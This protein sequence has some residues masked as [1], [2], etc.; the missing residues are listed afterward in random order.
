MNPFPASAR[1]WFLCLSLLSGP[2]FG[3]EI[4]AI[5]W[6]E[7]TEMPEPRDGYASGNVGGRLIIIGGTYWEGTKGDWRRKMFS[8]SS[9]ALN[10]AN[11]V[12]E[13]LP[14]APVSLGY[15]ASAQ[16]GDDIYAIGGLQDGKPGRGVYVLRHA[17]D[18]FV[19]ERHSEIPET[20]L[21]ASA[22]AV[23]SKIYV[24]GGSREYEPFDDKGTCC[25][26]NT[27]TS[28]VWVLDTTDT[29]RTWRQLPDYP[30][31]AR[32]LQSAAA[33][34]NDIYLFGGICL[35][36]QHQPPRQLNDVLHFDSAAGIWQRLGPLPATMQS[37]AAVRIGEHIVLLG[38][39]RQA[40]AFDPAT[41]AFHPVEPLTR[42]AMVTAF[43]WA[44]PFIVGAGGENSEDGP[45]RRSPWTFLGRTDA[46]A[47]TRAVTGK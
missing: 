13:R 38:P 39:G 21:F 19:F 46:A 22:V 18:R 1:P 8:R 7:S 47:I 27:A 31:D 4:P 26:S 44:E 40:V 17:D 10:P 6:Q 41:G 37:A 11:G 9:H 16:V 33:I 34:E 23:G 15:P 2:L 24:I 28:T 32:W 5:R 20:R 45:R 42:D 36:K 14:D 3:G 35:L 25:T 43:I 29:T 30:G 12:W